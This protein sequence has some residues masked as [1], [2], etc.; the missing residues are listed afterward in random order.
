VSRF[1]VRLSLALLAGIVVAS[2]IVQLF[3]ARQMSRA[4]GATAP[5]PQ[6]FAGEVLRRYFANLSPSSRADEVREIAAAIGARVETVQLVDPRVS[7]SVRTALGARGY[8]FERGRPFDAVLWTLE[9]RTNEVIGLGLGPRRLPTPSLW[10]ALALLMALILM[11]AAMGTLLARPMVLRLRQLQEASVR[12][13]RGELGARVVVSGNDAL[14]DFSRH[15][16]EMAEHNQMLLEKQRD[17]M[18]A[19]SHEL[20]TPAARI[21]F[22][23]ELLGEAN[24]REDRER[25]LATVDSD[26]GEI[27][28]LIHELVM[29]D[30]LDQPQSA[31]SSANRES[32][33]VGRAVSAEIER[34]GRARA[35]IEV[36]TVSAVAP[37]TAVVGSERLFRRAIRNLL[38]NGLRHARSKVRVSIAEADGQ[39]LVAVDDDGSGI[40]P[41]EQARDL[42]PFARLDPSR[43]RDSGGLG[44][45]LTIV[46]RILGAAGGQL[47]IGNNEFG[48]ARVTMSW[49][50][51]VESD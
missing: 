26:L 47:K 18:R 6:R 50:A 48:G 33:D 15:F 10:P 2:V 8:S 24:S 44:L 40:S 22:S 1:A 17:L 43:S 51:D 29:L 35:E 39:V 7:E 9:P 45:G 21:R 42:E 32:V 30:R 31:S 46:N 12:I 3:M 13:A 25:H 23:V 11:V 19:V 27:E 38:S 4:M 14:A 5:P 37:G 34:L 20:R 49:P 16:N 36:S 41:L 28:S